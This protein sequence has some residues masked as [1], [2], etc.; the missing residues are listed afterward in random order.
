M[1]CAQIDALALP[2][3]F[4]H[5]LLANEDAKQLLISPSV[6]V[7]NAF[8]SDVQSTR[9]LAGAPIDLELCIA[10][11]ESTVSHHVKDGP[12][13]GYLD[14]I[15]PAEYLQPAMVSSEDEVE[16][17]IPQS[18]DVGKD[19]SQKA[20]QFTLESL[21]NPKTRFI[22]KL[23]S[24]A[25]DDFGSSWSLWTLMQRRLYEA[26]AEW[27]KECLTQDTILA[28]RVA[29]RSDFR[30]IDF[31][32]IAGVVTPPTAES[33]FLERISKDNAR[34]RADEIRRVEKEREVKQ[35]VAY[36]N[37]ALHIYYRLFYP[38][39]QLRT[40]RAEM[41]GL[42]VQIPVTSSCPSTRTRSWW[43]LRRGCR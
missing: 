4:V 31:E 38:N 5:T 3:R 43:H 11:L 9:A 17:N 24:Y 7:A 36:S 33:Q 29:Y 26:H 40:Y 42:V 22:P 13:N 41:A 1:E 14:K 16:S 23:L 39:F 35:A 6:E 25:L 2:N 30:L 18:T 37:V 32:P 27:A 21:L 8:Q 15:I 20:W 28:R 34:W 10:K 12:S 19:G